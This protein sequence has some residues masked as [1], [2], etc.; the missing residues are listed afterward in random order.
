[1]AGVMPLMSRLTPGPD[2]KR[3]LLSA[4]VGTVTDV[5]N[6][7]L[8]RLPLRMMV[9]E[10]PCMPEAVQS[11]SMSTGAASCTRARTRSPPCCSRSM[12]RVNGAPGL[13]SRER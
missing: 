4:M 1:M 8:V 7:S 13:S 9:L 12:S 3:G 2:T 6:P 11:T 5:P 10:V